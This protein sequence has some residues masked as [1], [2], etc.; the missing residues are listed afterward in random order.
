MKFLLGLMAT[1]LL[2]ATISNSDAFAR[3]YYIKKGKRSWTR[4]GR[5]LYFKAKRPKR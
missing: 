3:T 2:A 1:S 4:L 5:K